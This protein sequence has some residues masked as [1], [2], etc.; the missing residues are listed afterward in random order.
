MYCR[1]RNDEGAAGMRHGLVSSFLD[2]IADFRENTSVNS[3]LTFCLVI[4]GP[5]LVFLTFYAMQPIQGLSLIH[6]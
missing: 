5:M 2:R 4:T 1:R 3:G 6:I